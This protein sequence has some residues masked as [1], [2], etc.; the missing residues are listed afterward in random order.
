MRL[1]TKSKTSIIFFFSIV[2]ILS[3]ETTY[4]QNLVDFTGNWVLDSGKSENLAQIESSTL[5]IGQSD[6]TITFKFKYVLKNLRSADDSITYLFKDFINESGDNDSNP[7]QKI[8]DSNSFSVTNIVASRRNGAMQTFRQITTYSL[9][10]KR[11]VLKIKIEDILPK[12]SSVPENKR[13]QIFVFNKV[14]S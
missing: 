10:N 4:G 14:K 9:N 13:C 8:V 7:G 1:I 12:D 6:S 2:L 3:F 11:N 5:V